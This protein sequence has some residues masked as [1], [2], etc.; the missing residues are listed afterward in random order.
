MMRMRWADRNRDRIDDMDSKRRII[1]TVA[2]KA[3]DFWV[4]IMVTYLANWAYSSDRNPII[5]RILYDRISHDG[6]VICPWKKDGQA[7]AGVVE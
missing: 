5:R 6:R 1:F 3:L 7:P 2:G 4:D